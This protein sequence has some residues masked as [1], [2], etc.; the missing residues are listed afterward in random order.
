[1][2][3]DLRELIARHSEYIDSAA[4][5]ASEYYARH[6]VTFEP[7]PGCTTH[8]SKED[9]RQVYIDILEEM[10]RRRAPF[11]TQHGM[12]VMTRVL[13]DAENPQFQIRFGIIF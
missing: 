5:E 3:L 4:K 6:D 12:F 13:G 10:I 11:A 8:V 1:M 2:R 7:F 9:C